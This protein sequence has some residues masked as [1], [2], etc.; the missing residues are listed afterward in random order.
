MSLRWRAGFVTLNKYGKV[1]TWWLVPSSGWRS[2][3]LV[4]EF[5]SRKLCLGDLSGGVLVQAAS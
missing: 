3:V 4:W 5:L 1:V 2:G